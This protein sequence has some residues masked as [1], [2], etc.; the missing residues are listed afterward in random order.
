MPVAADVATSILP[1][2]VPEQAESFAFQS[3]ADFY[4]DQ[5][6]PP[7]PRRL[8]ERLGAAGRP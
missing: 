7:V 5:V 8:H 6:L 4:N 3:I 1:Q 2:A